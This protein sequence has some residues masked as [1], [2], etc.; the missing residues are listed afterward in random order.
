MVFHLLGDGGLGK[1]WQILLFIL[2]KLDLDWLR[3][4]V[5]LSSSEESI[6]LLEKIVGCIGGTVHDRIPVLRGDWNLI[7]LEKGCQELPI[8]LLLV[9]L[10]AIVKLIHLQLVW[11]VA[12]E[13][14]CNDP[15]IGQISLWVG[16]LVG[17]V[18]RLDPEL[19]LS[20]KLVHLRLC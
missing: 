5:D 14:F 18:E 10:E 12:A 13:D 16:D 7:S 4:V 2:H 9:Q 6:E 20:W 15:T 17:Q 3:G 19:E 8:I 11:V 1:V